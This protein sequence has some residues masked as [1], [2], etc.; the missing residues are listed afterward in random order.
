MPSS[1]GDWIK[2]NKQKQREREAR[3]D[4]QEKERK[5]Q[6][7]DDLASEAKRYVYQKPPKP[8]PKPKQQPAPDRTSEGKRYSYLSESARSRQREAQDRD[9]EGKRPSYRPPVSNREEDK[10]DER[11]DRDRK[12]AAVVTSAGLQRKVKTDEPRVLYD[13]QPRGQVEVPDEDK[14]REDTSIQ[15]PGQTG[16]QTVASKV[17]PQGPV[18]GPP[19]KEEGPGSW[20]RWGTGGAAGLM[21]LPQTRWALETWMKNH[22]DPGAQ[23]APERSPLGLQQDQTRRPLGLRDNTPLGQST[24]PEQPEEPSAWAKYAPEWAQNIDLTAGW[25]AARDAFLYDV[26][27]RRQDYAGM[28]YGVRPAI[29]ETQRGLQTAFGGLSNLAGEALFGR[30]NQEIYNRTGNEAYKPADIDWAKESLGRVGGLMGAVGG[31]FR[32]SQATAPVAEIT[33]DIGSGMQVGTDLIAGAQMPNRLTVGENIGAGARAAG[34]IALGEFMNF[35]DPAWRQSHPDFDIFTQ[36]W[37]RQAGRYYQATTFTPAQQAALT[38]EQQRY[39]TSLARK[40]WADPDSV[41]ATKNALADRKSTVMQLQNAARQSY[42]AGS[43]HPEGSKERNELWAQASDSFREAYRLQNAHPMEIV[44]QNT[45]V[46]QQLAGELLMPDLTDLFAGTLKLLEL[47]PA[48]RRLA[49]TAKEFIVPEGKIEET[50][51]KLT[52]A[53]GVALNSLEVVPEEQGIARVLRD[54]IGTTAE[55][56]GAIARRDITPVIST[57]LSDVDTKADARI[58]MELAARD[59]LQ[60]VKGVDGSLFQS[61]GLRARIGADGLV[62]FGSSGMNSKNFVDAL[63]S[64]RMSAEE[65]LRNAPSLKGEGEINKLEFMLEDFLPAVEQG[66]Y[67]RFGEATELGEAPLGTKKT[68][69]KT[70]RDG[71]YIE[72]LDGDE[73]I[74]G[75]SDVMPL[76]QANETAAKLK[77]QRTMFEQSL[78]KQFADIERSVVTPFYLIT[79]PGTWLTNYAG[80]V[81]MAL[82]D[83]TYAFGSRAGMNDLLTKIYGGILPTDRSLSG[84]GDVAG[85]AAGVG[86]RAKNLI[87]AAYERAKQGYGGLDERTGTRVTYNATMRAIDKLLPPQLQK[88]AQTL[89]SNGMAPGDANRIAGHLHEV[90]RGGGNMFT[91]LNNVLSGK[92]KAFSLGAINKNWLE[93]LA[94]GGEGATAKLNEIVS[95]NLPPEEFGR[96]VNAWAD[97]ARKPWEAQVR[98]S[99]P[100]LQRYSWQAQGNVHDLADLDVLRQKMLKG[101]MPAAEVD[102]WY[103]SAVNGFNEIEQKTNLLTKLVTDTGDAANRKVLYDVWAGIDNLTTQVRRDL[104]DLVL[105]QVYPATAGVPPEMASSIWQKMYYEPARQMWAKRNE[106]VNKLLEQGLQSIQSGTPYKSNADYWDRWE[107][108]LNQDA[109][110]L[111]Q[112]LALDPAGGRY[113]T[114]L[115]QA[116][117]AG[118][119]IVDQEVARTFAL[120]GQFDAPGSFDII[121]SAEKNMQIAGA[122]VAAAKEEAYKVAERTGDWNSYYLQRNELSR[123]LIAHEVSVQ[124]WAQKSILEEAEGLGKDTSKA[125]EAAQAAANT[126]SSA[127]STAARVGEQAAPT[128]LSDNDLRT[129]AKDAGINTASAQGRPT[130][131]WLLRTINKDRKAQNLPPITALSQLDEEGRR[132]A[133]ESLHKR[134]EGKAA[135]QAPV[136]NLGNADNVADPVD[137]GLTTSRNTTA[138]GGVEHP[139]NVG[140]AGAHALEQIEA[141]RK[142][143]LEHPDEVLAAPGQVASG[144]AMNIL[145]AFRQEVL[146]QWDTI[147]AAAAEYSNRMRSFTLLDGSRKTQL[148]TLL[149][150][151]V[152][153]SFFWTRTVKNAAERM[154]FEPH[155]FK[156]VMNYQRKMRQRNEQEGAPARYDDDLRIKIGDD[157]YFLGFNIGKYWPTLES[158]LYNEY[159]NP[160]EANNAVSFAFDSASASGM[161]PHPWWTAG[162]KLANGQGQDVY[163]ADWLPIGKVLA[164]ATPSVTGSWQMPE[165]A[166]PGGYEYNLGR[167]VSNLMIK[168]EQVDGK[169]ITRDDAMAAMQLL[170]QRRQNSETLPEQQDY[171]TERLNRILD[172]A[173]GN[174]SRDQTMT[175]A[176]SMLLG[177]TAKP[178]DEAETIGTTERNQMFDRKYDPVQNPYGYNPEGTPAAQARMGYGDLYA[179]DPEN[180]TPPGVSLA[181]A[182]S[183]EANV[184]IDKAIKT[185]SDAAVNTVARNDGSRED[186]EQASVQAALRAAAEYMP[187]E[188]LDKWAAQAK[189]W[190]SGQ[191]AKFAKDWVEKNKYP[192]AWAFPDKE[193]YSYE[194]TLEQ[195]PGLD[196]LSKD[197]FTGYHN[198]NPQVGKLNMTEQREKLIQNIL[199]T[200]SDLD[201][202]V[203]PGKENKDQSKWDAYE[204]AKASD[205]ARKRKY[206][207]EELGGMGFSEQDAL[208]MF[209]DFT[210]RFQT[211]E[212]SQRLGEIQGESDVVRKGWDDYHACGDDRECKLRVRNS[213]PVF[214]KAFQE[215]ISGKDTSG[216]GVPGGEWSA[217]WGEYK[218]LGS[219]NAAKAKYMLAHP[220]FAAYYEDKYGNA[221]W[222]NYKGGRGGSSGN[223]REALSTVR[224]TYGDDAASLVEQYHKLPA[225][226]KRDEFAAAHPEVRL[227][228]FAGYNPDE[229]KAALEL[230]SEDDLRKWSA[231][232][233]D[234]EERNKYYDANPV[235]FLVQS[236]MYG[237]PANYD[238]SKDDTSFGDYGQDF[239]EA[240]DKFGDDIWDIVG[241]YKRG[242]SKAQKRAFYD[243]YSQYGE[244]QDWWYGNEGQV[245]ASSALRSGPGYDSLGHRAFGHWDIRGHGGGGGGGGYGGGGLPRDEGFGGGYTPRVDAPYVQPYQSPFSL[246]VRAED[247]PEVSRPQ[248]YY[249]TAWPLR[250]SETP[251]R[252]QWRKWSK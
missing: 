68:R 72:Y 194:P 217:E 116:I 232:P 131:R 139:D 205:D 26:A 246:H 188:E 40:N 74:L 19:T 80:A 197:Q 109:E 98:A 52:V 150:T 162:S 156:R 244:W 168:G 202:A 219:D 106:D 45:N 88:F 161:S 30:A 99:A 169:P 186:M 102:A 14:A 248:E 2:K 196:L 178:Y 23:S 55:S 237:R 191:V 231:L 83:G 121:A 141:L 129:L 60:L 145:N 222:K 167:E 69:V 184:S 174:V 185:A 241:Q 114:R 111:Q 235:A 152:P 110:K 154:V 250:A 204:K 96:A 64:F 81:S 6:E 224:S 206:I 243:K 75:Q 46:M 228:N 181:T 233:K 48:A 165:W 164:W 247:V 215:F 20:R 54:W 126:V 251:E 201:T 22:P 138:L 127:S 59:P 157:T 170:Y 24:A 91:E 159:A 105:N 86:Q 149:S 210:K 123:Q 190:N 124:R 32:L 57:L 71:A 225:G 58:I 9:S 100:Q 144:Q 87:S 177:V 10:R 13:I 234:K 176:E 1:V 160:S 28:D 137:A 136:T 53:P 79:Q 200:A 211:P 7:Q 31:P 148:D 146:P 223:Y 37:K 101:G 65:M 63:Q 16:G 240:G 44:N 56:Q 90:A 249:Y 29:Q 212:Q 104:G 15:A 122:Q 153:Y 108:A 21:V 166:E 130:D 182:Q 113:D 117:E 18:L 17:R 125:E 147:K 236:W 97:E 208:K 33:G 49:K 27:K 213:S 140:Q 227:Y 172:L 252:S 193:K 180:S 42:E 11:R 8:T 220:E 245:Y 133:A 203:Y 77:A 230:F 189:P 107:R 155:I 85:E 229:Y 119:A 207:L 47:T 175:S 112:T 179:Y 120:A 39:I 218:K 41:E 61:E 82:S 12:R 25:P 118:R 158:L 132:I 135:E 43:Q 171:D 34:D 221:W 195:Q 38:P 199:Y 115:A 242:W 173:A 4:K 103:K 73:N 226:R 66:S 76:R 239:T 3:F 62:R 209:D 67:R 78:V 238:E 214:E 95:A 151:F 94:A 216:S 192:S 92:T 89:V 93:T 143:L 134:T 5:K 36:P 70:T 50:L 183:K 35:F 128:V 84:M 51:G 142:W 198:P 187:K 163:P